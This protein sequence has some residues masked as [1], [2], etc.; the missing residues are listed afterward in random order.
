MSENNYHYMELSAVS[1]DMQIAFRNGLILNFLS[2]EAKLPLALK[3]KCYKNPLGKIAVMI[4]LEFT[5]ILL[6]RL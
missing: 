1:L 6:Y 3:E 5:F 2:G 4:G